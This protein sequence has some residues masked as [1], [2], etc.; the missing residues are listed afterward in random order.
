MA[1]NTDLENHVRIE[2]TDSMKKI[3]ANENPTDAEK[4]K[5][6]SKPTRPA[7]TAIVNLPMCIA[8]VLFC[9]TLISIRLTSGLYA[10]YVATG[11]DNDTARVISFG[12]VTLTESGDFVGGSAKLIP[13]VNL[14]KRVQVGFTGSE[15]AV[16]V[17][18]EIT[19]AGGWTTSDN[20]T[21]SML[22]G[23]LRWSVLTGTGEW[24]FLSAAG[25]TYVYYKTLGPNTP[26]SNVDFIANNGTIT[27]SNQILGSE[28]AALGPVSIALRATVV[29]A[30]GFAGASAAWASVS[31]R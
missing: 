18:V 2:R 1:Q 12:N 17:F 21:F 29:Q 4:K 25:G 16:Y 3:E 27:V 15:S 7:K 26:L 20:T 5:E 30:G 11:S 8:C 22:S 14:Q 31:G 23:K 9:L 24:T 6:V 19:P 10:K 13:G 28:L